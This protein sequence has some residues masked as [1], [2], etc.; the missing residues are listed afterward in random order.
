M[1]NDKKLP[2]SLVRV[3]TSVGLI[4]PDASGSFQYDS[5]IDLKGHVDR[6][7]S[8][9][10]TPDLFSFARAM[11]TSLVEVAA[12]QS[13]RDSLRAQ[14]DWNG[15][16]NTERVATINEPGIGI[17]IAC[18]NA[19]SAGDLATLFQRFET[20]VRRQLRGYGRHEVRVEVEYLAQGSVYAQFGV[21]RR[22]RT[23]KRQPNNPWTRAE[24]LALSGLIVSIVFGL[25]QA[26]PFK[27]AND[28]LIHNN[29]VTT[30]VYTNGQQS[31]AVTPKGVFV[32]PDLAPKKI[33]RK[34]GPLNPSHEFVHQATISV[35]NGKPM[36]DIDGAGA[37]YPIIDKRKVGSE[38]FADH[39]VYTLWGTLRYRDRKPTQ[40]IAT[41]AFKLTE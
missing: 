16:A 32:T 7:M 19:I 24:K 28:R 12:T 13:E 6:V 33:G 2:S 23:G 10:P 14:S 9:S 26:S 36:A 29:N 31:V 38:P 41:E 25:S 5:I 39:A 8:S 37:K 18:E 11:V 1:D 17:Y 22:R 15:N 20:V 27:K 40:I 21:F 30:I 4:K 34:T 3:G 35:V